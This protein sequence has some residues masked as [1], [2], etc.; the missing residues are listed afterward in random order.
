MAA[1]ALPAEQRARAIMIGIV[2]ATLMRI[3]FALM[4]AQLLQIVGLLFAGGLLLAWVAWKL[5]REIKG[6]E[7][8]G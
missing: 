5:W 6:Q 8:R 1:A 2:A 7:A 4:A 3:V